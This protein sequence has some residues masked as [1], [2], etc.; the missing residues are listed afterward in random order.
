MNIFI[1]A[2]DIS[3]EMH[4]ARLAAALKR[5]ATGVRITALG[6]KKLKAAADEFLFD[7]TELGGFGFWQPVKLYFRLKDLLRHITA[8]RWD[9][10]NKPDKVVLVDYYGFNIHLAEEAGKRG[11]PVYYYISPQVWASRKGRIKR[12]ARAV[13]KMLVILPFEEELYRKAGVDAVFVGHPLLD[14]VPA[15]PGSKQ[16]SQK[17]FIGLFPGSRPNVIVKHL[18]ILLKSAELI[19]R[20][21]PCE[22]IL[23]S[24]HEAE[25]PEVDAVKTVVDEDFSERLKLDFAVTVSGTV[26]LENTLLGIPMAVMYKLSGFNYRLAKMLVRT[27]FITMAN[28][29]LKRMVVPE[30]IQK[31]ANPEKIAATVLGILRDS[32]K[33]ENMRKELLS[34]RK[35]L[36]EP[37]VS[38]RAARII[39]EPLRR[40]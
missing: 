38:E 17:F 2:G 39:M 12:L 22:F 11:I 20:E 37:G 3:G 21:L 29:L 30:L 34:V 10:G 31:D 8:E 4:A 27:P 28:I 40:D 5:S 7:L 9:K 1:S 33:A 23:F 32:R 15:A 14:T 24:P 25:K 16:P 6:G 26:S 18:P 35:M 19:S 36:G 13:D